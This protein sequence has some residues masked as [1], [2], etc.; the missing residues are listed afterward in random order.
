MYFRASKRRCLNVVVSCWI[1][2]GLT[3]PW[4][5][6]GCGDGSGPAGSATS[7]SSSDASSDL[8]TVVITSAPA[9]V[10]PDASVP[11]SASDASISDATI[12]SDASAPDS[13]GDAPSADA[14]SPSDAST[15]DS[16]SDAPDAEDMGKDATADGATADSA[17]DAST[18]CNPTATPKDDDCVLSVAYGIFVATTHPV[19]GSEASTANE[20][21]IAA[22]AAP[23]AAMGDGSPSNPYLSISAALENLN[24]ASRIYIC[25]GTYDEQVTVT[26]P[27]S[28]YGGLSCSGAVWRWNGGTTHVIAPTSDYALSITGLNAKAIEVQDITF[29]APDAIQPG[30]SSIA[31]IVTTSSVSM[32][33]VVLEAGSGK[34]GA[35]GAEGPNNYAGLQAPGGSLVTPGMILC[36]NRDV[37]TGGSGANMTDWDGNTPMNGDTGSAFPMPPTSPGIDGSGG[38]EFDAG[39]PGANG[40]PG[41]QGLTPVSAGMLSGIAWIPSR[42]QDGLPGGPGEGG[43]GGGASQGG[44]SG[45]GGGAGGCGGAGGTGGQGGGTSIALLSVNNVTAVVLSSSSLHASAGGSGGAGGAGQDGQTGGLGYVDVSPIKYPTPAG[46]NGGNGAGGSG[47]G[48]GAGGLS[49]GIL[50]RGIPVSYDAVDTGITPGPA[51]TGG[52][53]GMPGSRALGNLSGAAGA[54]GLSGISQQVY[55]PE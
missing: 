43:G 36:T 18:A 8:Q 17:V 35:D 12:K 54:N 32:T 29:T 11:D 1:G 48:G 5:M 23:S 53:G 31:A 27:V 26:S 19:S 30:A 55:G 9:T 49:V 28:L 16:A 39:V 20:A 2:A 45:G 41:L 14:T 13:A 4:F 6:G 51:G 40:Q 3:L 21:G 25:E 37:S 10:E 24:G 22:D 52:T 44:G 38:Q 50:Y 7:N 46:G 34:D 15:P 33:R 42:G 47:G